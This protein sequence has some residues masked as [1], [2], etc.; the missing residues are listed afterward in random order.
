MW[1]KVGLGRDEVSLE[2]ALRELEAIDRERA[3]ARVPSFASYNTDWVDLLELGGMIRLGGII[4]RCAL[5]RRESR[6]GHVRTDHPERDDER[7]LKT[8]VAS[9]QNGDIAIRTLPVGNV[10][11]EIRPPGPLEG[12]PAILQDLMVRSLPRGVVQ[13]VLRKR[14]SGFIPGESA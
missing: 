10:W 7:W 3:N 2:T 6:G 1:Q 12:L 14:V 4:A 5:E 11:D 13:R 9:K 8:I